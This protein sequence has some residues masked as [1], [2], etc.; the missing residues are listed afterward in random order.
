MCVFNIIFLT[1]EH[2]FPSARGA[3][4]FSCC[5]SNESLLDYLQIPRGFVPA[6]PRREAA[7]SV[8]FRRERRVCTA[9]NAFVSFIGIAYIWF[10]ALCY[11]LGTL[12][13]IACQY[14]RLL[15]FF[16]LNALHFVLLRGISLSE[17][18]HKAR[19]KLVSHLHAPLAG[20]CCRAAQIE[21][22]D[23]SLNQ[24]LLC[25][26]A[27]GPPARLVS[28]KLSAKLGKWN[29]GITRNF[30]PITSADSGY[31]PPPPSPAVQDGVLLALCFA[32]HLQFR[33]EINHLALDS[34]LVLPRDFLENL[35]QADSAY[36]ICNPKEEQLHLSHGSGR[37]SLLQRT[38]PYLSLWVQEPGEQGAPRE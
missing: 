3:A 35:R 5:F 7:D 38:P 32:Q 20:Q 16:L 22:M 37:A 15:G 17:V 23:F 24:K 26:T 18:L 34:V 14:T 27:P 25:G 4:D 33:V 28:M 11:H 31:Y 12:R 36:M 6:S 21:G 2:F 8:L 9:K 13:A 10:A 29:P 19:K 30:L 1:L